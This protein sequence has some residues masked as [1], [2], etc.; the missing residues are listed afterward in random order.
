MIW[1]S[2]NRWVI[3]PK[4][5]KIIVRIWV[6]WKS[7]QRRDTDNV[8][9]LTLDA[10]T[11]VLYEDDSMCLPR[12]MNFDVDRGNPRIEIELEEFGDVVASDSQ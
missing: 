8:F 3:P 7:K 12:V 11:G 2:Q 5:T 10:L 4:E 9:K 6:Y 1:R